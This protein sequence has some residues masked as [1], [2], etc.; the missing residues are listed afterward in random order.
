MRVTKTDLDL[1][2]SRVIK[3]P[4]S[5]VWNAWADPDRLIFTNALPGGR[6]RDGCDHV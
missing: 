6:L 4:R 3:A 2:T 5:R 1:E